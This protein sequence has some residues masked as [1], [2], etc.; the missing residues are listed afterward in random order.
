MH[1]KIP[2]GARNSTSVIHTCAVPWPHL[3]LHNLLLLLQLDQP[4][5]PR[6]WLCQVWREKETGQK[7]F[8]VLSLLVKL[9]SLGVRFVGPIRE[10]A[11]RCDDDDD[12]NDIWLTRAYFTRPPLSLSLQPNWIIN[13]R[14]RRAPP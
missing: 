2:L 13:H 5:E 8:I 4:A 12:K 11:P 1:I 14:R 3:Q 7:L 9:P 10:A 6:E